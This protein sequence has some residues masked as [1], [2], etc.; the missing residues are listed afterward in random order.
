MYVIATDP[1]GRFFFAK[2]TSSGMFILENCTI[3]MGEPFASWGLPG[4]VW[5]HTFIELKTG[6]FDFT[7]TDFRNIIVSKTNAFISCD[8]ASEKILTIDGCTFTGCG[9]IDEGKVIDVLSSSVSTLTDSLSVRNSHFI[10]CFGYKGGIFSLNKQKAC[11]TGCVFKNVNVSSLGGC[12]FM[13]GGCVLEIRECEF[14]NI[15]S[16]RGGGI[17]HGENG[18]SV[19]VIST[20]VKNVYSKIGGGFFTKEV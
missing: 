11:I 2:Y 10:W 18:G 14:E 16:L 9:C 1:T 13:R 3:E 8:V 15:Y 7:D 12:M 20:E 4:S 6:S 19:M 5:N 17:L